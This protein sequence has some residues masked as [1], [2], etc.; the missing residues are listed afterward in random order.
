MVYICGTELTVDQLPLH[1]SIPYTIV[2]IKTKIVAL[3]AMGIKKSDTV[4]VYVN[5][6]IELTRLAAGCDDKL[7]RFS[8]DDELLTLLS[9]NASEATEESEEEPDIPDIPD[10]P[11]EIVSTTDEEV[12]EM[13]EIVDNDDKSANREE[14]PVEAEDIP[15]PDEVTSG[16]IEEVEVSAPEIPITNKSINESDM[17]KARLQTTERVLEQ[18]R[19]CLKQ[20][21]D[22]KNQVYDQAVSQ[23]ELVTAEY[24]AQLSDAQAAVENLK[25]QLAKAEASADGPLSHY[26][27]Y[28]SRSRAVLSAGLR[29]DNPPQNLAVVSAGSCDSVV[30]LAQSLALLAVSGFAGHIIDFTGDTAFRIALTNVACKVKAMQFAAQG[31]QIDANAFNDCNLDMGKDLGDV[32]RGRKN[33][34]DVVNTNFGESHVASAGF[35]HD[36][37]LLTFD[38]AGFI[39]TV[40]SQEISGGAPVIIVLPAIT[41]FVGEYLISYLGT[42]AKSSVVTTCAPSSLCS[43]EL[44]MSAI[45]QRRCSLLALNYVKSADSEARLRGNLNAK[46]RVKMFKANTIFSTSTPTRDEFAADIDNNGRIWVEAFA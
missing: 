13:Q 5:T 1:E 10:A 9:G 34:M 28:A 24:E 17:L 35:F 20:A 32:I 45:P 30:A 36:I 7:V 3:L 16:D 14:T 4:K 44:H 37:S 46:Y 39:N 12:A 31:R 19:S 8:S 43:T 11:A 33:Y 22:E 15:T 41:S 23:L 42:V 6:N 25:A 2:N 27:I 29:M 40:C 26:E 38:W 18:Q 21:E